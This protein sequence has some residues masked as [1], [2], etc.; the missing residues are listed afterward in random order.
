MFFGAMGVSALDL[1]PLPGSMS[2]LRLIEYSHNKRFIT[3]KIFIADELATVTC[4]QSQKAMMN[5]LLQRHD[6]TIK[7]DAQ[8]EQQTDPNRVYTALFACRTTHIF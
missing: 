6:Q 5:R 4:K 3:Y 2:T 8:T 7:T 1:Y